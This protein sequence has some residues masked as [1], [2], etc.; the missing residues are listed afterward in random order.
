MADPTGLV[1]QPHAEKLSVVEGLVAAC[2]LRRC[3]GQHREHE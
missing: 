3:G 2:R 1:E